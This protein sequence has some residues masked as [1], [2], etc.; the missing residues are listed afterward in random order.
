VQPALVLTDDPQRHHL[1]AADDQDGDDRRG[2]PRDD[3]PAED[4]E[5][6]IDEGEPEAAQGRQEAHR[7]NHLQPQQRHI[8]E[9]VEGERQELARIIAR[10]ADGSG[11]MVNLDLSD[12]LRVPGQHA[13]DEGE[14]QVVRENRLQQLAADVPERGHG[15]R[16]LEGPAVE[17]VDQD[18]A[19]VPPAAVAL[20]P[21]GA[22]DQVVVGGADHRDQPG[23]LLERVLE[24]VV[25]GDHQGP[26]GA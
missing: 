7:G 25:H 24:V 23:D 17:R 6:H 1:H 9:Q 11:L 26:T 12:P 19:E 4:V 20:R 10:A 13:V 2:V 5:D 21:V 16:N 15:H 3:E 8:R 22:V 14:V 18:A